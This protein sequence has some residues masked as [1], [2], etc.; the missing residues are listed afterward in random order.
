MKGFTE[1]LDRLDPEKKM[2]ESD[3]NALIQLFEDKMKAIKEEAYQYAVKASNKKL[4]EMDESH[5]NQL[6]KFVGQLKRKHQ[7]ELREQDEKH[8][9]KLVKFVEALENDH[10]HKFHKFVTRMDEDYSNKLAKLVKLIDESNT[11][12]LKMFAEAVK[13]RKITDKLANVVD[14]F[15]DTYLESVTPMS[16]KIDEAKLDRLEKFQQNLKEQLVFTEDYF[17]QEI[18]EAL[19]DANNI[20]KTKEETV[21]SLMLEK[22]ELNNKIKEFEAKS[23]L[24]EKSKDLSPALQ[25]YVQTRFAN[26]DVDEIEEM[27]QE[28]VE[29]FK[30][31]E[32]NKRQKLIHEAD[33]KRRVRHP[34]V[35]LNEDD[36][37]K[38][39]LQTKNS[40]FDSYINVLNKTNR[41]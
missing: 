34:K 41:K 11:K 19:L 8:T 22:I 15:L 27:F 38:N 14:G 25:S 10:S 18:K 17:N 1:I 12:K 20:I 23:L 5:T 7:K 4:K 9:K 24:T 30:S 21:D 6:T 3:R 26:A 16:K 31:E 13:D 32:K 36:L 37:T 28:A 2:T 29:A 39:K 35:Q 40:E 33:K